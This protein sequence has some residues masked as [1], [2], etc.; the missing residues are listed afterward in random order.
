VDGARHAAGPP[1][2][3]HGDVERAGLDAVEAPQGGGRQMRG[4]GPGTRSEH[5]T[6]QVLAPRPGVRG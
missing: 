5:R 6:Q 3:R 4:H 2:D 1:A